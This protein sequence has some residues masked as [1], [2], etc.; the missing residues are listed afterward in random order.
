LKRHVRP[1]VILCCALTI[2][3][4]CASAPQWRDL[5]HL[6]VVTVSDTG[7]PRTPSRGYHS[8]GYRLSDGAQRS[9]AGLER[10]YRLKHVDGWPIDLL[11]LYCAVMAVDADADVDVTLARI[12]EDPRVR[13][14]E[15]LKTFVVRSY[16]DPIFAVSN[17]GSHPLQ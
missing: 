16:Y 10:D 6:V 9:L 14:S 7:A 8:P 3:S 4:G 17:W 5:S 1:S 2:L 12:G 13:M 15:T 11:G